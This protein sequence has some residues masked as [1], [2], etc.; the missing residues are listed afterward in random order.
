[1]TASFDSVN[2]AWLICFLKHRINDPRAMRLIQK[3]L[4]AGILEDLATSRETLRSSPA[5]IVILVGSG[6]CAHYGRH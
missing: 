6:S 2:Q 5:T 1:V 4:K 3:W